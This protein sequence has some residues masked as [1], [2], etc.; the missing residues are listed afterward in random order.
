MT[1]IMTIDLLSSRAGFSMDAARFTFPAQIEW[2]DYKEQ[3]DEP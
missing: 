2:R 3:Y 1:F